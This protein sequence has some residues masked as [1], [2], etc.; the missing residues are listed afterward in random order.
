MLNGTG[1]LRNHSICWHRNASG[2]IGGVDVGHDASRTFLLVRQEGVFEELCGCR[3]LVYVNNE[4]SENEVLRHC[5]HFFRYFGVF[6]IEA[7]LEHR[8]FL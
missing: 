3:S 6:L 8:R 4:A 7:N 2:E 1:G 5:R